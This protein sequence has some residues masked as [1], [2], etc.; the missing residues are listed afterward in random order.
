MIT[1]EFAGAAEQEG[2]D[3][4]FYPV[5]MFHCYK[6]QPQKQEQQDSSFRHIYYKYHYEQTGLGA[7]EQ[8]RGRLQI[9]PR[10]LAGKTATAAAP[11][12]GA[13]THPRSSFGYPA[14]P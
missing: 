9:Q 12:D 6:R 3:M 8:A 5:G 13:T 11:E 14:P 4:Q 2:L 1:F 10:L 7:K